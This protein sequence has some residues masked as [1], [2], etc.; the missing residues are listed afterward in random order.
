STLTQQLVKNQLLTNDPTFQR[1]ASELLLAFKV[2][3][4]LSKEEILTSY[5]NAVSFGRNANGQNIAGIKSAAKGVFGKEVKDLNL[6]EASFL[7]GMPQNPYAYT[8]FNVDGS[9]KSENELS[10]GKTRQEYVL[11]RV[12]TEGNITEEEYDEAMNYD[13]Y[14]N[15]TSSVS[16]PNEKYPFVTEEIERRAVVVLKYGRAEDDGVSSEDL[17]DTPLLH[18]EY[19]QKANDVL[20]NNGYLS[21][22]TI[23]K[24]LYD[25][26][27]AVKDN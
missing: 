9:L 14:D 16:V 6:A 17:D 7:A 2:E 13:L 11:D 20:R 3:D 12:L 26:M 15:M 1:K 21:G 22:T 10:L 5:L 18:E 27:H 19:T 4:L 23:N 25:S 8:P 24:K